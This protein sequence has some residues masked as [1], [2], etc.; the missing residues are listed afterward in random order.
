MSKIV[1]MSGRDLEPIVEVDV[2][3]L[4]T[5]EIALKHAKAGELRSL[6][7]A[8]DYRQAQ[9]QIEYAGDADFYLAGLDSNLQKNLLEDLTE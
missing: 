3:I 1:D 6:A 2:G 4:E 8:M 9:P 5:L 7:I